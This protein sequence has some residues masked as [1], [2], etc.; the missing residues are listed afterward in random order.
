MN[1]NNVDISFCLPVYNVANYVEECIKSIIMQDD[2]TYTYEIICVNDKSTDNSYEVLTELANKYSQITVVSNEKN[3]G[4]SYTRNRLIDLSQGKYI[5]FVDPDDMIYPSVVPKMFSEI[6]SSREDVNII[7]GNYIFCEDSATIDEFESASNY[8]FKTASFS[9][10]DSCPTDAKGVGSFFLWCG[11]Y[12][13]AFLINNNVRLKNGLAIAEDELFYYDL[14]TKADTVIKYNG[15]SYLYRRRPSSIMM[16]KTVERDK[17]YFEAMLILYDAYKERYKL[18]EYICVETIKEAI[19]R[20][21]HLA[22]FS[23]CRIPDTAYVKQQLK[24]LKKDKIYPNPFRSDI[25][26]WPNCSLAQRIA[27]F[28]LPIEP[29]FWINHFAIK[30][31]KRNR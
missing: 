13:R 23:L 2:G 30:V 28:L 29:I 27:Q 31:I 22:I 10:S 20:T 21:S 6:E 17:K 3:C 26:K 4:V 19:R 16:T 7:W 12:K 24:K 11:M 9:D 14:G 25:L 1:K 15:V 8:E 5:W 18:K